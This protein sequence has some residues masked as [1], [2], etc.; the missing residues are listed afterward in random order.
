VLLQTKSEVVKI[1]KSDVQVLE[2]G[3]DY[4]RAVGALGDC[5]GEPMRGP[6]WGPFEKGDKK[7]DSFQ[8][9]TPLSSAIN[10]L[11]PLSQQS[12]PETPNPVVDALIDE[13][14]VSLSDLS[15]SLGSS[16]MSISGAYSSRERGLGS[17]A[18][19]AA[20]SSSSSMR[21]SSA[22][23]AAA[24]A[25]ERHELPSWC[26]KGVLVRVIRGPHYPKQ[27]NCSSSSS[28]S[29]SSSKN[30]SSGSNSSS[31][32][33]RPLLLRPTFRWFAVR[34]LVSAASGRARLLEL[35][36]PKDLGPSL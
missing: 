28:S 6:P 7:G 36:S 15:V 19:A 25:A 30:G 5:W 33:S 16:S 26:L 8:T 13:D 11:P 32:S 12:Q 35:A 18:S 23:A 10:S 1:P 34:V 14:A 17:V 24:A 4:A 21:L 20:G 22:T 31:S 2:S 29:S 9:L 27:V 3:R